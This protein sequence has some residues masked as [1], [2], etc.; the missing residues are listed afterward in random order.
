MIGLDPG[1]EALRRAVEARTRA[2]LEHGLVAEVQ[3]LLAAGVPAAA[4]PLQSIGYRQ[5]LAVLRGEMTEAEAEH[6]IATETMRYAKRQRTWF[7]HQEPGIRWFADPD[8][9]FAAALEWVDRPFP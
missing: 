5:A 1:R 4:R 7:R 6:A 8:A 9:A 3:G 2:M